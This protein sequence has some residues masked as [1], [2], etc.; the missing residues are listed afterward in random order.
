MSIMLALIPQVV[1]SLLDSQAIGN[2]G[3]FIPTLTTNIN[4]QIPHY[5]SHNKDRWNAEWQIRN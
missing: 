3:Y 5:I 2:T 1:Q 4:S